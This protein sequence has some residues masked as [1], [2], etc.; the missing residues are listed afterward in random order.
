MRKIALT[1]GIACGKSLAGKY[2]A[3]CGIPVI[4]ADEVV[5]RLLQKDAS[6]K[7]AILNHFGSTV[8]TPQGDVDRG[9]LGARV[10]QNK[11]ERQFLESLLHPKVR[12]AF[13]AFFSEQAQ[14]PLAVALIPLLFESG[15]AELYDEVW[16]LACSEETQLAR[17]V[18]TRHMSQAD[19]LARIQ[20]QMPLAEK[21]EKTRQHP[22]G[23]LIWNDGSE[24]TLYD[25]LDRLISKIEEPKNI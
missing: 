17:L 15:I 16:L 21:I 19:A 8:F 12:E 25:E 4:D 9:S 22:M 24:D 10:F 5:H 23:L 14:T 7:Q 20:S 1:G 18:S 3:N 2:L 13:A 11:P 6:V